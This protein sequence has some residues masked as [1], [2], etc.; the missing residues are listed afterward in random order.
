LYTAQLLS[1]C[2]VLTHAEAAVCGITTHHHTVAVNPESVEI[3]DSWSKKKDWTVMQV[4]FKG[5]FEELIIEK[6][7]VKLRALNLERHKYPVGTA[8]GIRIRKYFEY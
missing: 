5:F 1:R 4:L 3:V 2:S 8:V 7:G 6:Q